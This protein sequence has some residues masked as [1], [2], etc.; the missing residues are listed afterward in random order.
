MTDKP[1]KQGVLVVGKISSQSNIAVEYIIQWYLQR[2]K[3][4]MDGEA[5]ISLCRWMTPQT[6]KV[7]NS[8]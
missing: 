6:S 1:Q 5:D 7:R 3:L 4:S 8:Y 2:R